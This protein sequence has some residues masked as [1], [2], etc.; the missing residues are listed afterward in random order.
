MFRGREVFH[1][2]LGKR[3]LD[4]M[5]EQVDGTAK[6]E[7][8][9][10]LD[11][12]NMVMVLAPDKRAKQSAGG[13]G[14]EHERRPRAPGLGAGSRATS[15]SPAPV[16]TTAE[17]PPRCRPRPP[18]MQRPAEEEEHDMPKMKTDRG[19]AKRFKVTGTGQDPPPQGQPLAPA[20]EEV[21]RPHPSPRAR[22]RGRRRRPSRGAAP[23]RPLKPG[24]PRPPLVIGAPGS[25]GAAR[26]DVVRRK[27]LS[28]GQ[29]EARRQRQ[30]APPGR[31]RVGPGL[32]RQPSRTFRSANEA[33]MHSL[34]Y[35][36]RDR[37]A[38]KGDFRRLWIQRINA[39]ARA[40][41]H[42]LQPAHRRAPPGRGRAS[43]ARCSPISP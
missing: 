15:G 28:H 34:Q 9:P 38:R 12:R 42:E 14:R 5:A 17:R 24:R 13:P 20:R 32:L 10:R 40:Q 16:G 18:G 3:I 25:R 23:A 6:V 41:R 30:E 36:Y 8:E 33:V 7:S 19:A 22:G 2:E 21:S 43:T 31:P 11:G 39:A 4:R 35:A 1:P 37:R 29:G 27:E 26:L